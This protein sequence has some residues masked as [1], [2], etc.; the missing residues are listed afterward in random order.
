MNTLNLATYPTRILAEKDIDLKDYM[1]LAKDKVCAD[2]TSARKVFRRFPVSNF[3]KMEELLE[4]NNNYYE[5]LPPGLPVKPYFDLEMEYDG[6]TYEK[7]KKYL[8]VF[9][10]WLIVEISFLYNVQLDI[11]DFI[12]LNSCR[13]NKLSFHL[14]IQNKIYFANVLDHNIFIKYFWKRFEKPKNEEENDIFSKLS[15]VYKENENRRIFDPIPYGKYQ[16]FRLVNQSKKGKTHILKNES[17]YPNSDTL[18]RLYNGP[19][20]RKLLSVDTLETMF[21]KKDKKKSDKKQVNKIEQIG[22]ISEGLTVMDKLR[23]SYDDIRSEPL[24][25]Q[26]LYLIPNTS[27]NWEFYRNIAFAVRGCNGKQE[28]FIIWAGLSDKYKKECEIIVNFYN[29]K[30]QDDERTYGLP[31]LKKLANISH[32]DFFNHCQLT[33]FNMEVDDEADEEKK[34]NGILEGDDSDAA[35][36]VL[37]KYPHWKCCCGIL[38]VF[39]DTTGMWSDKN[40]VHNNIISRFS[41]HLNI[42]KMTPNGLKF[43]GKNY[44]KNN[45]KRRDMYPFIRENCVDDNWIRKTESSS[46]GKILFT[47][48]HYDFIRSLFLY[49]RKKDVS[50]EENG[51]NPDIVFVYRIDHAYT[52]FSLEEMTYMDTIK[53]RLFIKPL[54]EDVGN[55]LIL[56]LARGLAGDVMKRIMFGLGMSNTGK[57]IITKACQLSMGQYCGTFAAENLSFNNTTNDEAQKM[58]WAFLL[59]NKRLII[60]NEIS[61][62]RTLDG[63][64]I[65]KLCSGGDTI[66]GRV[67]QGLETDFIPQYLCV[68][69]VNDIP[70]IKPYDDAVDNRARVYSYTKSFVDEP[71]NDTELKKDPNLENEIKNLLFQRCFIGLLIKKYLSFQENNRLEVEASEVMIAKKDWMG[72]VNENDILTKFQE[73]YEFSN[74]ESDYVLSR[75][76]ECWVDQ[77]KDMSYVKFVMQMKKYCV[78]NGY[79][80]I[81]NKTKKINSKQFK[82]WYGIKLIIE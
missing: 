14:I 57:G 23:L 3:D 54:G 18:V 63:I 6:L 35:K 27:Q 81:L 1:L 70:K 21:E 67:H 43:T 47:N 53:D 64:I 45:Q 48:G 2:D 42:V 36:T 68:I 7:S 66:Q 8:D 50:D 32:P 17:K 24:Y 33:N 55:Y 72:S 26:Y 61:M 39:D 22:F 28:D 46:L 15:W 62:N 80:N 20:E 16:N 44:A 65:K 79:E 29:Y 56:N 10:G 5:I 59:K 82:A 49:G 73:I 40:D 9:I 41:E 75:D 71:T 78:V 31:H 25:L 60:S 58:R 30:K 12:E 37:G 74:V 52:D 38:Y 34:I 76:I 51:F 11:N 13:E 69:L 4:N 19:G 77:S